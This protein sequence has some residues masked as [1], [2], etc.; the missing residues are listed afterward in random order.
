M[1][2][3]KI[4]TSQDNKLDSYRQMLETSIKIGRQFNHEF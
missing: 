2:N 4:I 1:G 3:N